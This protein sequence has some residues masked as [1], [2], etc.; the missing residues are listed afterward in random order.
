MA[1]INMTANDNG[2]SN[3]L[4]IGELLENI[5]DNVDTIRGNMKGGGL[6]V[7]S[8]DSF[9]NSTDGTFMRG[10]DSDDDLAKL[11]TAS[12]KLPE[13]KGRL[14]KKLVKDPNSS[15]TLGLIDK[16]INEDSNPVSLNTLIAAVEGIT[17]H[18]CES[19]LDNFEKGE[20]DAGEY[21]KLGLK[22]AFA[23]PKGYHTG[24]VRI[25]A[26][27]DDECENEAHLN[28]GATRYTAPLPG[29]ASLVINNTAV[30]KIDSNGNYIYDAPNHIQQAGYYGLTTVT[31]DPPD[32]QSIADQ[33]NK[34]LAEA[35]DVLKGSWFVGAE[36][37]TQ[38]TLQ[39]ETY[40]IAS[41][42]LPIPGAAM[43]V[44]D[45]P[46]DKVYKQIKVNPIPSHYLDISDGGTEVKG[47]VNLSEMKGNVTFSMNTPTYVKSVGVSVI[48]DIY[49][50]LCSI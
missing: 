3:A 28:I 32:L 44:I 23:I 45:A 47:T 20:D 10:S 34:T 9:G 50:I 40:E 29:D 2:P 48:N 13:Y 35:S 37:M 49:D 36:G 38:G 24:D 43:K 7:K 46:E 8:V 27:D 18:D 25:I 16:P 19:Y 15:D 4:T 14:Y 31:I 39:Y 41:S 6:G 21:I 11:A 12:D 1:Q 5:V 42:D 22:E 17:K 33:T 30:N 26:V